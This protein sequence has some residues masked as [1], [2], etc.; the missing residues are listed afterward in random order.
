VGAA[1]IVAHGSPSD[2]AP[3]EAAIAA[4]ARTVAAR[5]SG[6]RIKGATLA[7]PGALERALEAGP[8]LVYPLFMSDGWFVS[9][10]L[11]RRL[12]AAG[13]ARIAILPPLGLDPAL[14][15]LCATRAREAAAAAGFAIPDTT[16]ILAAHG[17]P[18]DPRPAAAAANVARY[19]REKGGF[20]AIATGFVDEAPLLAD[21]LR[22]EGPALCLPFFAARAGHVTGDLP[23]AV[24]EA[25]FRGP[26]LGP[27]GADPGVA[28]LIAGALRRAAAG[29]RP[30]APA[31]AR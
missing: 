13:H 29:F 2:P 1:L 4:L 16:V 31:A 14:A 18:K 24:A 9:R 15:A 26:V 6:W 11:P 3:Q 25:G 23:E 17:S 12:G 19:L 30:A 22:A 28:D 27:I 20:R 10:E 7:A 8:A 21:A 5:L